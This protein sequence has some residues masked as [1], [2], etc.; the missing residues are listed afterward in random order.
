[1]YLSFHWFDTVGWAA[2]KKVWPVKPTGSVFL[3]YDPPWNDS[4]KGRQ[5][6]TTSTV[7]IVLIAVVAAAVV[8]YLFFALFGGSG[9]ASI[10]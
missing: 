2:G 7:V 8:S 9:E 4:R 3:G 5:L 1:M 10:L 6:N